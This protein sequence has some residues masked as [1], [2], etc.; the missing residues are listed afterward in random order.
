MNYFAADIVIEHH[1]KLFI[2]RLIKLLFCLFFTIGY[3]CSALNIKSTV[4]DQ[5]KL[6]PPSEGPVASLLKQKITLVSDDQQ[7]Q[8]LLVTRVQTDNLITVV[9]SATGQKVLTL[10]YDG[11]TLTQDNLSS[12]DIPR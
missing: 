12:T 10:I 1:A 11:L 7:N 2:S 4:P 3:G 9:L 6:L 5:L 8:F